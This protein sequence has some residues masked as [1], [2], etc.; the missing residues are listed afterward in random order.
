MTSHFMH[1]LA[2]FIAAMALGLALASAALAAETGRLRIGDILA[3]AL[4]GE[5]TLT[6]DFPIDRNG[7]IQLPEVGSLKVA[8]KTVAEASRDVR[9]ALAKAYRDLERFSLRLKDRRLVVAVAG[10]VKT[11][12]TLDLAGD[13]TVQVAI[14]GA[15]GILAGA[16]LDRIKIIRAGK[17]TE[18]NYKRYLDTGD[19]T[20]LPALEPLD[21]I[22]VPSSPLTGNVQIDF[23]AATL[24]RA[25]DG[26]DQ[27][28][29]I[30]VFGE[31]NN[32]AQFS[33]KDGSSVVDVLMRAGGVTRYAA[34]EQIRVIADGQPV[35]F[36]LQAYLD[37]GDA[38][39]LPA[40]KPGATIFVPIQ[41]EQVKKGKHTVYV[42]GEVAKPGALE[43][44]A[45]A[46]FIDVMANAGGPTRYA[47][48]RNIRI[49]RSG[50]KV[51]VFDLIAFTEGKGAAIPAIAPGDAILVPEKVETL[52]PS[53]LKTPSSRAVQV[54]GAVTKPGRYEW[55]DEM[56]LFD[57]LAQAGGPTGKG[58]MAAISILKNDKARARPIVFDMKAFL[59]SGGDMRQVPQIH[60]GYVVMVPELPTDPT[61]NKSQWLSQDPGRSIY[62]MGAVGAPGRYAF[63]A[64][65]GFLDILTAA[66]GPTK[67]A[68][69]RRI[70]VGIRGGGTAD[71]RMVDLARYMETGDEALLPALKPG[72]LIYVP[73][74]DQEWTEEPVEDTVRVI[75]A[76][77]KPGRYR[78]T[79]RMSI[80]DLLAEAGGP[81]PDA[82]Q[83]RIVVVNMGEEATAATFNLIKFARSADYTRLPV[84]R[85][86]D[87]VYVPDKSQSHWVKAMGI[88]KDAAQVASFVALIAAL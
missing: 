42:M 88:L 44:Q 40:L 86:G 75:G 16:Q 61:D 60:A 68:D 23:D 56:T 14:A 41:T 66:D 33:W 26:A 58:D 4:P 27:G 39:L 69:L 24:A 47:D 15:G 34:V 65:M 5:E 83:S 71:S 21:V 76:V 82:L 77:A 32:P 57:L 31:V 51:A 29:A 48:T 67:T 20:L 25:G 50:G 35:L 59:A 54:I 55:S 7:E 1:R 81:T 30:K 63:D 85:V 28:Q 79:D 53:W 70:R 80:L 52:E 22:F 46:T 84:V 13:A 73:D 19:L 38:K 64:S 72:D 9:A 43:A 2:T 49:I 3:L 8:G 78:F 74:R 18:I 11:P 36:N 45:G 10:Q 12:G 37:S 62:V 6:A 17:A 87:T